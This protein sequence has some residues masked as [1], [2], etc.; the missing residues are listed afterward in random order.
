MKKMKIMVVGYGS[1]GK[2]HVDNLLKINDVSVII[3]TKRKDLSKKIKEK[4][5]IVES[6][7]AGIIEKPRISFIT[8]ATNKHMISAI[9]LADAGIHLFI[10]KPL[11]NS[12]TEFEKLAKIVKKKKLVTMVG[13]NLRFHECVK[14]IK[15]LLEKNTIGRVVSARAES[16]SFLPDW[17]PYEDYRKSYAARKKLGGGVILTCI[18]ELDY[19][20]WF[21]GEIDNVFSFSE[22]SSD[23]EIDVEDFAVALLKFKNKIVGELELN[24]FQKPE[25]RSCRIIGTNGTIYWDSET[26]TVKVYDTDKEEWVDKIVLNTYDRNEMYMK[27]SKYFLKCVNKNEKTM[28]DIND[29]SKILRTALGM[30]NSSKVKKVVKI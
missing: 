26:N 1:I 9:K 4:C 15:N 23:L 22:K 27:E 8:N 29:A 21:F 25:F 16:G 13:C 3:C 30:I 24:F 2:R 6:I 7:D 14:T 28:N 18:H 11:S 5:K 20:Y 19:L 10:E 17:H 12:L